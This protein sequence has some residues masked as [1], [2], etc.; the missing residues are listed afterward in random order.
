[1]VR[2]VTVVN[3][4]K[5]ILVETVRPFGFED[6]ITCSLLSGGL[7]YQ[8]ALDLVETGEVTYIGISG[9]TENGG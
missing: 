6:C 9:P 7:N 3:L 5:V 8:A 4:D 1:M 2:G